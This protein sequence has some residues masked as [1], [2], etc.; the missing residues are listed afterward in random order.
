MLGEA[1]SRGG[2]CDQAVQVSKSV[3]SRQGRAATSSKKPPLVFLFT[4]ASCV[5][6]V[7]QNKVVPL[8]TVSWHWLEEIASITSDD[9]HCIG[10]VHDG[11]VSDLQTPS[12]HPRLK[13]LKKLVVQVF[14]V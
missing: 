2:H 11:R 6:L 3:Q 7:P 4:L 5:P 14:E 9:P 12:E 10:S 1:S 8:K 13:V